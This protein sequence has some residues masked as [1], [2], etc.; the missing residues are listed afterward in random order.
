MTLAEELISLCEV[1]EE[2]WVTIRGH[3]ILL[4]KD[5]VILKGP[6]FAVGKHVSEFGKGASH[7]KVLGDLKQVFGNKP[8]YMVGGAVRDAL[9]GK[10]P[11]DIDM[12]ALMPPHEL[13]AMGAKY[14][15]P[16]T[17]IPVFSMQ[18]PTLGKIEIA[19]PRKEI[20]TGDK[21][22]DFEMEV[23][24]HITLADD[25]KR[26]DFTINSMAMDL[27]G[28]LVDPYNGE[29]DL[30]NK[31][32]RHTS[33]A[34][35]ED[36]LRVFRAL[37]FSSKGFSL[38]P[39]LSTLLPKI[40]TTHLPVERIF[41]ET[42]KAMGEKHPETYFENLIKLGIAPHLFDKIHQM[43]SVPAGPEA[44]HGNE[45]VFEH[46]IDAL[47][48]TAKET[49]D[50]VIRLSSF[51]HDLGKVDT[52]KEQLPSHHD[53]DTSDAVKDFLSTIKA[54]NRT[55]KVCISVAANHMR[56]Q[57]LLEMR[58]SKQLR[59]VNELK[60]AGAIEALDILMKSDDPKNSIAI[61]A[62]ADR[63]LKVLGMSVIELGMDP[64]D[65]KM[66]NGE[67]VKH[68]VEQARIAV[69]KHMM[70]TR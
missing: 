55:R 67:V 22:Q 48:T 35:S 70:R 6:K 38:S 8:V 53:H 10:Q 64:A 56:Y 62:Q 41:H 66:R 44:Y 46:C 5:G 52:P 50:P 32:L 37:R 68:M 36:A 31:I 57:R 63:C 60:Q 42:V 4:N 17:A 69:L 1:E 23:G 24:P 59:L 7:E 21:H 39:E 11:N 14:I 54:D 9:M 65:L 13:H 45:S 15:D 20:K 29:A 30:K 51:L 16:K 61:A 2:R 34:F 27:D 3:H 43:K 58:P 18:H 26:R 33:S 19:L 25:L 49:T 40:D 12:V 28:K 47:K